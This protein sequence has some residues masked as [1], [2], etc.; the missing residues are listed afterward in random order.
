M[1]KPKDVQPE[2]SRT[3]LEAEIEVLQ[4]EN[5]SLKGKLDDSEVMAQHHKEQAEKASQPKI[6]HKPLLHAIWLRVL[7]YLITYQSEDGETATALAKSLNLDLSELKPELARMVDAK[8]L[9]KHLVPAVTR[10]ARL[11]MPVPEPTYTITKN[12]R[13]ALV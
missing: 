6:E 4:T 1:H 12:G 7:E 2:K 13:T 9:W 10:S 5:A 3:E 8:L 11:G